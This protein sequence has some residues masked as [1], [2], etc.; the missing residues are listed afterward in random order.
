MMTCT[1]DTFISEVLYK[2]FENEYKLL[3]TKIIDEALN[4]SQSSSEQESTSVFE[5]IERIFHKDT[6]KENKLKSTTK[7][8][9][10]PL[11]K[12]NAGA[13]SAIYINKRGRPRKNIV[14]KMLV[15]ENDETISP[16][17]RKRGRPRLNAEHPDAIEKKKSKPSPNSNFKNNLNKVTE[18]K[19]KDTNL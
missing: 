11:N 2:K 15:N 18:M 17:K 14:E 3:V 8:E 13:T 1:V 6:N 12:Q 9:D 19:N 16:E 5:N 7:A 10:I 4:E